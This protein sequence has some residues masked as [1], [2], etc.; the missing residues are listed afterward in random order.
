TCNLP[1]SE[2]RS[3]PA[4]PLFRRTMGERVGYDVALHPSLEAI[5]TDG[6]RR[7][8]GGF[9]VAR[10]EETPLLLGVIGPHPCEAICLKFDL[11]LEL[12]GGNLIQATLRILS[13]RQE[14]EQILHVVADLVSDHICLRELTALAV[15]A[16]VEPPFEVL[17]ERRVEIDLLIIRAIE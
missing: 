12:V 14:P 17:K 15:I 5:V 11:D 13:L 4:R 10:L 2:P 16:T 6:G 3:E 8:H 7:L 1:R 9:D